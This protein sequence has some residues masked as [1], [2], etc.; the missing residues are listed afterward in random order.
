[1]LFGLKL[2]LSS[3]AEYFTVADGF[4]SFICEFLAFLLV[5]IVV[6]VGEELRL[7]GDVISI[8]ALDK[9]LR[10]VVNTF[11]IILWVRENLVV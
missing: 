9:L 8:D 11:H 7:S 4:K 10:V 2:F 1:M 6:S 3:L 5:E